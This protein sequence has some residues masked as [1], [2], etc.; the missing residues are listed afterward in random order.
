D[1]LP[2]PTRLAQVSSRRDNRTARSSGVQLQF[3]G[4]LRMESQHGDLCRSAQRRK[5]QLQWRTCTE[6]LRSLEFVLRSLM[7]HSGSSPET[8]VCEPCYQCRKKQH[9]REV[10]APGHQTDQ[11][12]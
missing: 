12:G 2:S 8:S 6:K 7:S 4:R 11:T 3:P 9:G 5:L 1:L 10:S